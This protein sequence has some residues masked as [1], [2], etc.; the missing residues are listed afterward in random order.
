MKYLLFDIGGSKMRFAVTEDC[1]E[2][3]TPK[4][5]KTPKTYNECMSLISE[6]AQEL[7]G[8]EDIIQAFGGVAGTFNKNKDI[9]LRAPHLQDWENKNVKQ[10]LEKILGVPVEIDNDTA[11]IALGEAHAGAG[12]GYDIVAYMTVS[13]GVGGARVVY[14]KM[15][16]KVQSFE[17]GHQIIDYKV[18]TTL[19]QLVSGTGVKA[20][21]G[22]EG[23]EITDAETWSQITKELAVGV[24]NT[25]LHWSPDVMVLG[26]SMITGKGPCVPMSELHKQVESMSPFLFENCKIVSAELGDLNGIYGALAWAKQLFGEK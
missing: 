15:D 2:C 4:I 9:L 1:V 13:T 24:H 18:G 23:Y 5:V 25:L 10:D 26:G 17:P 12:R 8:D 6:I 3:T 20:R 22:K 11:V 14:G 7:K 16:A 21:F 19:E